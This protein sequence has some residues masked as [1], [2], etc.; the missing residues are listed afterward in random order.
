MFVIMDSYSNETSNGFFFLVRRRPP[1][2]PLFP[3]TPLFRSP[4][5]ERVR[6]LFVRLRRAPI[7]D[8]AARPPRELSHG[9]LLLSQFSPMRNPALWPQDAK[10]LDAALGDRQSTRLN[11]SHL[12]L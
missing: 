6:Q 7:P 11:S 8:P 4:A 10:D 12:V 2:S 1:R 3:S 9:D 5:A